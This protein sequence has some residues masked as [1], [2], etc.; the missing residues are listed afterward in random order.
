MAEGILK[1]IVA[2]R[3][4][5]PLPIEVASAGTMGISGMPASRWSADVCAEYDID[6]SE[7]QSQAA[8]QELLEQ[9][10]LVL[11]MS[12]VHHEHCREMGVPE[13]NLF[14]LR[15][16]PDT[17]TDWHTLSVPDPVGQDRETYQRVF[18]QM[19]EALQKG[20]RELFARA[21]KAQGGI[22]DG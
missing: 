21:R 5:A 22:G 13:G 14:L 18:F 1:K 10:D 15:A 17:P 19:E 8:S 16:F 11:V 12:K 7:H 6:L 9:S 20:L 3:S 2:G 4:D